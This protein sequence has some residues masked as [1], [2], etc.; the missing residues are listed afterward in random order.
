MHSTEIANLSF[1]PSQQATLYHLQLHINLAYHDGM[2]TNGVYIVNTIANALQKLHYLVP[3]VFN[4]HYVK[5]LKDSG[6]MIPEIAKS[7]AQIWSRACR[8]TF[9]HHSSYINRLNPSN[10]NWC[11]MYLALQGN[12]GA[13]TQLFYRFIRNQLLGYSEITKETGTC[14]E[15]K[16][17]PKYCSKYPL[18][19]NL[20]YVF[21]GMDQE[22]LLCTGDTVGN[23]PQSN[24]LH[25]LEPSTPNS[26]N[27]S[28]EA[29]NSYLQ[30]TNEFCDEILDEHDPDTANPIDFAA[31]VVQSSHD[32]GPNVDLNTGMDDKACSCLH[33]VNESNLQRQLPWQCNR[34]ED[35]LSR[36]MQADRE[37]LNTSTQADRLA[38]YK[39][40]SE[41]I[42]L[43]LSKAQRAELH[44]RNICEF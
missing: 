33:Q 4:P 18:R 7:L 43:L 15:G 2:Q 12:E 35:L 17:K 1:P 37:Y 29:M 27:V 40:Q 5:Q 8:T 13:I 36:V 9:D 39:A 19:F 41:E 22:N 26:F 6:Q 32:N 25:D 11:N 38:H 3:R 10:P 16:R 44:R 14:C 23:S 34:G 21:H 20:N 28:P 42:D 24:Y 31:G 30:E